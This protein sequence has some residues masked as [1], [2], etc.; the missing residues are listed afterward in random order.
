M[1]HGEEKKGFY[2]RKIKMS[3]GKTI[4]LFVFFWENVFG[5]VKNS[6]H[7]Q[8]WEVGEKF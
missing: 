8:E 7:F 3:S 4:Y 5:W 6:Y 2:D 1:A